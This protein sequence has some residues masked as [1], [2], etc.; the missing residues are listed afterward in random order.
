MLERKWLKAKRLSAFTGE[1]YGG[2]PAWV[3][4]GAE[5]LDGE[6]MQTL[7]RELNPLSD[8]AFV[9]IES[10]QDADLKIK[11]F[12]QSGEIGFSGHATVASYF[13]L[14][15]ENIFPLV[16]PITSIRQQT[17]SGIQ[18]VELRVKDNLVSRAT[19]ALGGPKFINNEYNVTAIARMLGVGSKE[20]TEA[21]LPID[22]VSTGFYNIIIPV[23]S[24]SQLFDLRP[25]FSLIEKFCSRLG[26]AGLLVFC[27]ETVESDDSAHSRHFAPA[28]G[29]NED[30]VSGG[31]SA[32]LGC[33][34]VKHRLIP[35]DRFNRII[36]EQGQGK[37]YVHVQLYKE[38]IASVKVGGQAVIT[39]EGNILVPGSQP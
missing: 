2:N 14:S 26:V 10:S 3:V 13:A 37:V 28:V 6:T 32:S 16:E 21:G 7:A 23:K 22:C 8:T 15:E 31:A 20:I 38:Q 36:I 5:G 17:K 33:Y 1:P 27:L 24:L 18:Y 11:F 9:Q 34:L 29:I 25:D 30:P 19:V 35:L 39:F 4:L 12:S